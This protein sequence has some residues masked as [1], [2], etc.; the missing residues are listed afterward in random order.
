MSDL[1]PAVQS[2]LQ[3]LASGPLRD[4]AKNLLKTLGYQSDR[5]L[6]LEGSKP[7]AFLD[8]IA[9]QG[10][11]SKFDESKALFSDWKSADILFQLSDT[12][13]SQ[14]RSLFKD[15]TVQ[16]GLL[17]SYLFFAIELTGGD[18][19]RG[20][21]TSIARQIN[22]VFPMPVM[23][24]IR[25]GDT[26]GAPVLSIAVINRRRNKV[27]AEKDVLEKVT[28][29]RDVSLTDPHRGHLDILA[30]FAVENLVHPKKIPITDFDTLH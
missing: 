6:N 16:P 1:R 13:I 28:L 11:Q 19:A 17:Q 2:A 8:L 3:A 30:S 18:Y 26:S 29:I 15:T 20:K 10:G 25:H 7:Q 24:L 12:D 21:L 22:R 14:E 23:L 5:T 9:S 27:H 4:S